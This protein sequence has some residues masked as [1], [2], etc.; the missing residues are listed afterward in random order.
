MSVALARRRRTE[1]FASIGGLLLLV[2]LVSL[3]SVEDPD[4]ATLRIGII[5]VTLGAGLWMVRSWELIPLAVLTWLA[6]NFARSLLDDR[7]ELFSTTMMLE[8][9]GVLA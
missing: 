1:L 5:M 4:G 8:A 9:A 2:G 6:P 3:I 7:F